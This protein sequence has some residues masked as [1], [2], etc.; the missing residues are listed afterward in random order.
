[1]TDNVNQDQNSTDPARE[2]GRKVRE[3]FA[4]LPCEQKIT[5]LIDIEL[6]LVGDVAGT[7]VESASR[8]VRDMGRALDDLFRPA[9]APGQPEPGPTA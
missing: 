6:D 3:A 4:A 7:F 8:A 5:T 9:P 1:M 2:A